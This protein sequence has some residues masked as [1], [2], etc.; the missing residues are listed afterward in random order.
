MN[1]VYSLKL[2]SL[3]RVDWN[4]YSED[5]VSRE[6]NMIVSV[7]VLFFLI[8]VFFLSHWVFPWQ[9]FNEATKNIQKIDTQRECYNLRDENLSLF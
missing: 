7:V 4:E 5:I 9:G 1:R 8:M 6:R 2:N 3:K